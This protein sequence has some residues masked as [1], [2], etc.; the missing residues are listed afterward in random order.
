MTA[1]LDRLDLELRCIP[2]VVSVSLDGE[3]ADLVVQVVVIASLSPPDIRDR[4]RRTVQT[5]LRETVSLEV[6]FDLLP[7]GV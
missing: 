4:I 1:E 3:E 2:G 7:Q 6:V 5:N